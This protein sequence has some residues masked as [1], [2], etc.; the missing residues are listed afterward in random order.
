MQSNNES[1][2]IWLSDVNSKVQRDTE[3]QRVASFQALGNQ[4]LRKM[5]FQIWIELSSGERARNY[6]LITSFLIYFDSQ[7]TGLWK[8]KTIE[9]KKEMPIN[10]FHKPLHSFNLHS[11]IFYFFLIY[12]SLL[13]VKMV[14]LH[15]NT[16]QDNTIWHQV[17]FKLHITHACEFM[18]QKSTEQKHR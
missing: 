8:N 5:S 13:S 14:K 10:V 12:H 4:L 15:F 2:N 11:I 18:S 17:L 3:L 7:M 1:G 9:R 6:I 16:I